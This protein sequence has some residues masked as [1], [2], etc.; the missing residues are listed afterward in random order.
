MVFSRTATAFGFGARLILSLESS[1]TCDED[2]M[3]KIVKMP[4][5]SSF[6]CLLHSHCENALEDNTILSSSQKF[7]TILQ[8]CLAA[9]PL[10]FTLGFTTKTKAFTHAIL[11]SKLA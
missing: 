2:I 11:L 1:G 4:E 6:T 7:R 5:H 10:T 8:N 3:K 9:S